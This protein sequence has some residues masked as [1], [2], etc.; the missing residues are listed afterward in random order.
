MKL[1]AI[2]K[3]ERASKGQGG[4]RELR[5]NILGEKIK[6]IP[7]RTNLFEIILI[8]NDDNKL[9]AYLM[10]YT[11]ED[12]IT[13]YPRHVSFANKKEKGKKEKGELRPICNVCG[14]GIY[15]EDGVCT[16]CKSTDIGYID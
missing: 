11:K 2:T 12:V 9:E 1:Y 3:S 15:V 6:G 7:T 13:L 14:S 5:I 10:D 4:N 16:K 8:V